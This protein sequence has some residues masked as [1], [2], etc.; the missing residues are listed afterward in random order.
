MN[1]VYEIIINCTEN[2]FF[3]QI[4]LI[5]PENL[6]QNEENCMIKNEIVYLIPKKFL[7]FSIYNKA[8]KFSITFT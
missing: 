2:K 3:I 6:S 4:L 5:P 7:M 8:L 1:I